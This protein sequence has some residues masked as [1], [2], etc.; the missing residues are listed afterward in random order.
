MPKSRLFVP[1][2]VSYSVLSKKGVQR[3]G[4]RAFVPVGTR[5]PRGLDKMG[6]FAELRRLAHNSQFFIKPLSARARKVSR[7]LEQ[8]GIRAEKP[9]QDLG[10]G[11]ALFEKKG[12]SLDS[13]E[14][15]AIFGEK[16]YYYAEKVMGI[17]A[18]MHSLG[19]A[20]N[21]LHGGNIAITPEGEIIL[22]D[23]GRATMPKGERPSNLSDGPSSF[24][25]DSSTV[26]RALAEL[27]PSISVFEISLQANRNSGLPPTSTLII[28]FFD[29]IQK[30]EK[31][32]A[33]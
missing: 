31:E 7:I 23:L 25:R 10:N 3:K 18:K 32:L 12:F 27:C 9:I 8:N 1:K 11:T 33:K 30:K 17:V 15:R 14:A 13:A 4:T 22:L 16:P 26:A 5:L 29:A 24:D 19:I 20:H 21:H 2:T 28:R 6:K